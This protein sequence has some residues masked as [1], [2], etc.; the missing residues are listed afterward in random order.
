MQLKDT[1]IQSFTQLRINEILDKP[2]GIMNRVRFSKLLAEDQMWNS[3]PNH[4]TWLTDTF[5]RVFIK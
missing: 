2:I 4:H 5:G 3:L 1:Q